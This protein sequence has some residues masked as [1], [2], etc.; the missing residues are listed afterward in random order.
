MIPAVL[1]LAAAAAVCLAAAVPAASGQGRSIPLLDVPFVP[2]SEDLCGGAAAAMVMRYWGETGLYAEAFAD[3]VDRQAGGIRTGDLIRAIEARGWQTAAVAGTLERV[4]GSLA[5]R[6]PPIALI[7]D[8][9]G[10]LHYVVVVGASAG[11]IVLH[12]PARA[13]FRVLDESAFL[14][15]WGGA[16]FWM[17]VVLPNG[18]ARPAGP[19]PPAEAPSAAASSPG[20][21]CGAMVSEAVRLA[22]AGSIDDAERLLELAADQCPGEP[23]PWRE[24]AGVYALRREWGP[25]AAASRRALAAEPRDEHSARILATSLFLTGDAPGALDAWNVV[26]EPVIDLVEIRGLE[27]TRFAVAADVLGL[28]PG[29]PLTAR[30]LERAGRRLGELP[31]AAGTRVSYTPRDNGLAILT[32]TVIERPLVPASAVALAASGAGALADRELQVKV[33]SPTGGGELW[34]ASWR[35]WERRPRTRVALTAPA[36]F[37]GI[38]GVELVD[39]RQTYGA[40]QSE[41]AERRRRVALQ[42]GDWSSGVTA[43]EGTLGLERW[44]EGTA[45]AMSGGLRRHLAGDRLELGADAGLWTGAVRTWSARGRIDWRSRPVHQGV[46]WIGGAAVDA[47]GAAAPSALLAGAGT[48]HARERLLRA[49]PL[50]DAGVIRGG[51]FGRRVISAGGEWRRW[52]TP[53]FGVVRLGPAVFVDAARAYQAPDFADRRLHVDVGAGLRLAFPGVGVLRADLARGL[54]DGR[55]AVSFGWTR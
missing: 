39:D 16:G 15:A 9:P 48:G 35:W 49:H 18:G 34:E 11:R 28:A 12:D 3:L 42:L 41:V 8:R 5:A 24:L 1:R 52:G 17:L 46:V 44:P 55:M 45:A 47:A 32:A 10:R 4:R 27:R 21:T 31:S 25:A 19:A 22:N 36:P 38:W 14:R 30:D 50:L 40:P 20:G 33:A 13:P 37:G 53:I 43:W 23:A 29:R 26:G 54:R 51:V 2:Q 7:E 6:R